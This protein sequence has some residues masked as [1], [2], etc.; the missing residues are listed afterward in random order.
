ML[1]RASKFFFSLFFSLFFSSKFLTALFSPFMRFFFF[2][3][4]WANIILSLIR[5]K[6]SGLLGCYF[7]VFILQPRS[8]FYGNEFRALFTLLRTSLQLFM[9]FTSITTFLVSLHN[10]LIKYIRYRVLSIFHSSTKAFT[11]FLYRLKREINEAYRKKIN[12][13][14]RISELVSM[15]EI[16][17][18]VDA[19]ASAT[20]NFN[21][22]TEINWFWKRWESQEKSEIV[23]FVHSFW[24]VLWKRDKWGWFWCWSWYFQQASFLS[25]LSKRITFHWKNEELKQTSRR[26]LHSP[27]FKISPNQLRRETSIKA[28]G[29]LDFPRIPTE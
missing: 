19:T 24:K 25:T 2:S 7:F 18:R 26:S 20:D 21:V 28:Y 8:L 22:D 12:S 29:K 14:K 5:R 16:N 1:C 4:T 27:P 23:E 11:L 6:L 15:W 17:E 10:S 3:P 13:H 9:E